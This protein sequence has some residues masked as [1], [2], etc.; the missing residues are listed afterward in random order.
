MS[1]KEPA[2]I[3]AIQRLDSLLDSI[4]SV[5]PVVIR[6]V[7]SNSMVRAK[8]GSS[9]MQALVIDGL[10]SGQLT[11]SDISRIYNISKPNVTALVDRLAE[12]G[13]VERKHDAQDR[14]RV[15]ISVTAKGRRLI[16]RRRRI[17]KDYVLRTLEKLQPQEIDEIYISLAAFRDTLARLE[18]IF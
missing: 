18:K 10:A 12:R 7:L 14:R 16:A 3:P 8:A 17:I 6:K 2:G 9:S 15:K 1:P 5:F 11:A 4:N 13:Y